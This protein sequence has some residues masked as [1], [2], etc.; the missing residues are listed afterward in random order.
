[1][2]KTPLTEI[3]PS[4]HFMYKKC[5]NKCYIII[6]RREVI[7]IHKKSRYIKSFQSYF[8][9]YIFLLHKFRDHT[10]YRET[11]TTENSDT[12]RSS[13][14]IFINHYFCMTLS[15]ADRLTT[16][17]KNNTIRRR[18]NSHQT[19]LYERRLTHPYIV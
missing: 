10:S 8:I 7:K 5:I 2:H 19:N 17:H 15:Y 9:W 11:S 14:S 13:S 3:Q 18:N 4:S 1:M 6:K 16:L 12:H